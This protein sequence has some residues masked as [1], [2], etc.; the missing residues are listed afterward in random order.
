MARKPTWRCTKATDGVKCNHD[1]PRRLKKCEVC[2]KLRSPIKRPAHQLA[3][4]F[5]YE[6]YVELNGG[7]YCGICK[8]PPS[9]TRRLDRD[10]DHRTGR[11]RGLLCPTCNR[12]LWTGF[13]AKWAM[14]A[15]DYLLRAEK[16]PL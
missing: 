13:D 10:H 8:R 1:N 9:P 4:K 7:E 6:Y 2:G 14:A 5:P 16:H 15:L 11:P 12:N 3:L